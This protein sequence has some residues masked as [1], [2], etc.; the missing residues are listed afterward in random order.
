M[1]PVICEYLKLM[2]AVVCLC[3]LGEVCVCLSLGEGVW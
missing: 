2:I 1:G 3:R